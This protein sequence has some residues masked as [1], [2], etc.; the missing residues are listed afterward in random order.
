MLF[1]DVVCVMR[2]KID[3]LPTKGIPLCIIRPPFWNVV[4]INTFKKSQPK[5]SHIHTH[6]RM[7]VDGYG[8]MGIA[9]KLSATTFH[10]LSKRVEGNA[11]SKIPFYI[12][13]LKLFS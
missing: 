9:Q 10:A 1:L 5:T 8:L 4:V 12:Y 3:K 6:E 2:R 13:F 11:K 7:K